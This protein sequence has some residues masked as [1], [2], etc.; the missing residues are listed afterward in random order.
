MVPTRARRTALSAGLIAVLLTAGSSAYA[1]ELSTV[2]AGK[3]PA[4]AATASVQWPTTLPMP[5]GGEAGRH[6]DQGLA[7]SEQAQTRLAIRRS[8]DGWLLAQA[9][10]RLH[11]S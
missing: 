9:R 10:P 5:K 2:P 6:R 3:P 11:R 7:S 1:A 4:P 8:D